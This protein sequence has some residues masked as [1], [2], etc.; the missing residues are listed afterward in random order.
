MEHRKKRFNTISSRFTLIVSVAV[1]GC[2]LTVQLASYL[3]LRKTVENNSRATMRVAN[4]SICMELED[5]YYSLL[6][7]SQLMDSSGM[8]GKAFYQMLKADT[9]TEKR[10]SIAAMEELLT[11]VT[12]SS[13]G[14]LAIYYNLDTGNNYLQGYQTIKDGFHPEQMPCLLDTGSLV[15]HA[16]HS[17]QSRFSNAQVVSLLRS[18][19]FWGDANIVIYV[20]KKIALQSL[21][22][23]YQD[24]Y[25]RNFLFLQLN[26]SGT[27]VYSSDERLPV[28]TKMC[29]V[30]QN[31][32]DF[33]QWDNYFWTSRRGSFGG[34]SI[35]LSAKSEFYS[36][37]YLQLRLFLLAVLFSVIL[38]LAT[39]ILLN[40]LILK[41]H[42]ILQQEIQRVG[43]G[44]LSKVEQHT[45][46]YDYDLLLDRFDWM[47]EQLQLQIQA[48]E[49]AERRN[50]EIEREILYYQINPHFLLNSLNSAYWQAKMNIHDGI[51]QYIAQLT[52]ILRY[53]L[54]KDMQ[55]PTLEKEVE[56]LRLYL[57][58]QEKRYDFTY[59]LDVEQG[60]YLKM[61]IPRLF[62]QPVVENSI[63]HGMDVGGHINI[64]VFQ[65]DGWACVDVEDD[66]VGMDSE[67][68]QKIDE[69]MQKHAGRTGIGLR[70]VKTVICAM[71]G[72][73]AQMMIESKESMGTRVHLRLPIRAKREDRSKIEGSVDV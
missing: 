11:T 15:Y 71:F 55:P 32:S 66:G 65:K 38:I 61:L 59:T 35:L 36:D 39:V 27:V 58:L 63:E 7:I 16:V 4:E 3:I 33:G 34:Y 30:V 43:E 1:V 21:L 69:N 28:G 62:I 19:S 41:K 54:G 60:E 45:G 12:F 49:A 24:N 29:S 72:E 64:Q 26:D 46:L 68:L 2:M 56:I 47:T 13:G 42:K 25:E 52:A 17:S 50:G 70:Y 51:D 67:T 44:N 57:Q 53:S 9:Y 22:K 14:S 40:E 8:V 73:E 31:T 6:Q 10:D 23:E 5:D 20:E 37:V 48:A 18:T